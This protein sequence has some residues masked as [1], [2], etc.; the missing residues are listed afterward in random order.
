MSL[1]AWTFEPGI[2]FSVER[3]DLEVGSRWLGTWTPGERSIEFPDDAGV[4][5]TTSALFTARIEYRAP[6]AP[7]VDQSRLRVWIT[8]NAKSKT[9]REAVVVRS[10]RAAEP[11]NL[12]AL[13]PSTEARAVEVIARLPNGGVEAVA[14]LVAPS[15]GAHPTYQLTRPLSLP[16]G[17]RIEATSSVHLLYTAAATRTVKPNV[18]RRPR[19]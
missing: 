11:V 3:V 17:A 18:R 1:T 7:A 16:A 15:R 14:A 4:P 12:V 10:W 9:V 8:K 19:R 13:R 6:A 2:P 5:L